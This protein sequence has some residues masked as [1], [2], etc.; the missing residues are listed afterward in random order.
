MIHHKRPLLHMSIECREKRAH[1]QLVSTGTSPRHLK[2]L[3]D[4]APL[5]ISYAVSASLHSI[6]FLYSIKK[7]ASKG[8]T[9]ITLPFILLINKDDAL[10]L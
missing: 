2:E 4:S 6:E 5:V 3:N 8:K 1:C 9:K 7:K 10:P